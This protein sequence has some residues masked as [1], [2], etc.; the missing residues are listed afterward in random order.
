MVNSIKNIRKW[1]KR[2]DESYE[3]DLS[4]KLSLL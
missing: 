3:Y 2:V 4:M 1:V